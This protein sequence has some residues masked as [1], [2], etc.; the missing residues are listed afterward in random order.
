MRTAALT[1]TTASPASPRRRGC[2]TIAKRLASCRWAW[3]ARGTTVWQK[4]YH[5]K[6]QRGRAVEIGLTSPGCGVL[7]DD[8]ERAL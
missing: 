7:S 8:K 4:R 5:Y 3:L 6:R 2:G 1:N